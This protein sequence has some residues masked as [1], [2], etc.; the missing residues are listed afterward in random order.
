S[1]QQMAA[2]EMRKF[3]PLIKIACNPH[4]QLFICTYFAPVC[5]RINSPVPPCRN[6]CED[7]LHG[8]QQYLKSFSLD[9][10][11]DFNCA[12]FPKFGGKELCI[13]KPNDYTALAPRLNDG[14]SATGIHDIDF[15]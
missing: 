12:Q 8:C 4:L 5:T 15:I 11:Q 6:L 7:A 13:W 14:E 9:L 1:N 3:Q 10:Q 2:F